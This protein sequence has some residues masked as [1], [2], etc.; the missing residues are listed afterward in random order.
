MLDHAGSLEQ[1]RSGFSLT[2]ETHDCVPVRGM[3]LPRYEKGEGGLPAAVASRT[4]NVVGSM[5][6]SGAW[7]RAHDVQTQRAP[8]AIRTT[9]PRPRYPS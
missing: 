1:C 3:H 8:S 9:E 5:T 4:A 6:P 2:F 7:P